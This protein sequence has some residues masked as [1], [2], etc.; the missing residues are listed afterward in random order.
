MEKLFCDFLSFYENVGSESLFRHVEIMS[1]VRHYFGK[2]NTNVR[3]AYHS[4]VKEP[5]T[6]TK[7]PLTKLPA[8]LGY[9]IHPIGACHSF[10]RNAVLEGSNPGKSACTLPFLRRKDLHKSDLCM[11][12]TS[13]RREGNRHLHSPGPAA[14]RVYSLHPESAPEASGIS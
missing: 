6:D 4:R 3:I 13:G 8:A 11:R 12:P 5:E 1:G 7:E 9:A 14:N 2:E 10:P